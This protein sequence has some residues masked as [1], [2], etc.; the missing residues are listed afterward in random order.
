MH[1]K[2]KIKTI[3]ALSLVTAILTSIFILGKEDI[4]T[5]YIVGFSLIAWLVVMVVINRK[6]N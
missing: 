5:K 1:Q 2:D 4:V 6:Y 3:V